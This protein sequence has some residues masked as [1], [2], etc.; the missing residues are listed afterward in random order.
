MNRNVLTISALDPS[1]CTGITVDLKTLMAWRMYGMSVTT[2][3]VMQNTQRVDAVYPV[4]MEVIGGQLESIVSDIEIHSAKI[5]ILPNA[6]TM[7]LVI[8]LIRAFNLQNL[9]VDPV[10]Q[11]ST[12]YQIADEKMIALY[13]EKLFPLAE[14]VTP[15][16]A[17]AA[18]F[19]GIPVSEITHMKQAAEII[20]KMGAKNVVVTGGHLEA[21]PMDVLFDGARHTVYDGARISS[22]HTRGLGDTFS[23]VIAAHLAKKM[24]VQAAVDPARKYIAR[25]MVHPF[26]IGA[27]NG[28]LN[29]N[30][31]I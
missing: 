30:V 19:S 31:A 21:R 4:P 15:N 10:L 18:L 3:I 9:V 14:C 2:A 22:T 13:K 11:T 25:A 23:M 5:G 17:E 28:P 24:K 29:H 26:K 27:G 8:E 6:K 12:G 16:M 1:G 7:E 20:Q